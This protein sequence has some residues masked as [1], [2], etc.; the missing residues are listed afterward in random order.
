MQHRSGF[1]KSTISISGFLSTQDGTFG[2]DPFSS[3]NGPNRG[4]SGSSNGDPFKD[5]GEFFNKPAS[6]VDPFGTK[7]P[8][9]SAFGAPAKPTVFANKIAC[10]LNLYIKRM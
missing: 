1:L 7:D 9:A 6:S 4:F 2:S 3:L 5:S 10:H 8:F